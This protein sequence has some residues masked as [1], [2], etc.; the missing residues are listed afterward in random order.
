MG[1]RRRL[2]PD[3]WGTA[4]PRGGHGRPASQGHRAVNVGPNRREAG[5]RRA[6]LDQAVGRGDPPNDR[7][8]AF[9]DGQGPRCTSRAFQ[10][11]LESHGVAQSM[12]R[13][14]NP[15]DNAVAESLFKTSK[16]ELIKERPC[17]TR[18]GAK[19]EV[20]KRI[21]PHCNTRRTHSSPGHRAPCDSERGATQ[22][23]LNSCPRYL[24]HSRLYWYQ[25]RRMSI[26]MKAKV[27]SVR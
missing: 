7:S 2:R 11:R 3:R 1:R 8:L 14:G 22:R 23:C 21:E 27:N 20:F 19:R 24:D 4:L 18:G 5:R 10:R 26:P 25:N 12:P 13:P 16:R 15:R 9:H 17:R 6:G